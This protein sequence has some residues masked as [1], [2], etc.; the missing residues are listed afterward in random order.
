[1]WSSKPAGLWRISLIGT[2]GKKKPCGGSIFV[3]PVLSAEEL[4]EERAGL[5]GL[6]FIEAIGGTTKAPIH[7]YR[8]PPQETE[9]RGGEELR[10]LG[11]CQARQ[12]RGDLVRG[13][14]RRH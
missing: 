7:R 5:S 3:W 4:L 13:Q 10:N 6:V 14:H 9:I 1:M 8:F 2:A 12:G 11:G